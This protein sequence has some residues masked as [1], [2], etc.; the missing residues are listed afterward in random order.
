MFTSFKK[1][2]AANPA[3]LLIATLF[4]A[5]LLI[6][7]LAW[8][9]FG[10]Q[11]ETGDASEPLVVFCAAGILPPVEEAAAQF[12]KEV[13]LKIR[14]M[15]GNSGTLQLQIENSHKGDLYIPAD[16]SFVQKLKDKGLA[17]EMIPLAKFRLVLAVQPG[18]PKNIETLADLYREDV[19]Y[20]IGTPQA[21]F[22]KKARKIFN[23]SGDW[24]KL[25]KSA[26]V[27]KTTVRDAAQDIGERFVDAGFIWDATARQEKLDIISIP[28]LN[29]PKALSTITVGVLS[30][31][32]RPTDALRFARYLAASDRGTKAFGKH[33]YEL[34]KGDPWAKIPEVTLYAGGLNS[35]ACK[36]IVDAFRK[37]EGVQIN[38]DYK[39]CGSLVSQMKAGEKPDM[40]FACD[41]S[42][43]TKVTDLFDP[44]QDVS[45]TRV[46]MLVP[47]GSTKVRT[48][49]DVGKAGVRLGR[50]DPKLSA[51]GGLTERLLKDE[52]VYDQVIKNSTTHVTGP[53]A[54][55]L[56]AQLTES[57]ALDVAFVYEAN[58]NFIGDKATIIA[59][60]NPIALA[61]QPIAVSKTT[62]YPQL[63]A[64]L[65][66]AITNEQSK[67]RFEQAKF[68]WIWSDTESETLENNPK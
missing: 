60:E 52:G 46:V 30:M 59:I 66:R 23:A 27:Q 45:T 63:M 41:I 42:Y 48:F 68:K 43:A 38:V 19:K 29:T 3:V 12:E 36:S 58:C 64:R 50:C 44:F 21:A 31:C 55:Y 26:K 34:V 11:S 6:V 33:D 13:G 40:Y 56:V 18:N 22:G 4:A 28:E 10:S 47:K 67:Q 61:V 49:A 5:G 39:G 7:M 17:D 16:V 8:N 54:D 65:V 35:V 24:A 53:T 2:A 15:H 32:E 51:L 1:T 25:E 9:P 20:V 37:R 62:L 57:G 14:F